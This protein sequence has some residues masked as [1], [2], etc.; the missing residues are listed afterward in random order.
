MTVWGNVK[1]SPGAWMF[2]P[3]RWATDAK[4]DNQANMVALGKPGIGEG[5][6]RD[7]GFEPQDRFV[8]PFAMEFADPEM[9]ARGLASTGPAYEA[10][11]NIG[12]ATFLER[13]AALARQHVV[14]GVPLRGEVQL[15]GYIGIKQ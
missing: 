4:V 6:L 14:E 9:Y 2:E 5:F 8:V 12:E 15:F 7:A 13:A 1:K 10:I 3:F 11:Q